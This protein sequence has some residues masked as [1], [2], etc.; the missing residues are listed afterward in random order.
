MKIALLAFL[1]AL[2]ASATD[3]YIGIDSGKDSRPQWKL[4]LDAFRAKDAASRDDAELAGKLANVVRSDLM[5]SRYFEIVEDRPPV[6]ASEDDARRHWKT[7]GA[8]YLL[9]AE[10]SRSGASAQ[11]KVVVTDL[12]AGAELLS[13]HYRREAGGWRAL[14]HRVCDDVVR[15]L[16]G[17]EGIAST[18]IAF[19]GDR[20]GDKEIFVMDYDGENARQLTRNRSINLFPRWRPDGKALAFTSYKDGN[21]DLFLYDLERGKITPL[22]DRQGLNLPGGFSR[23][24]KRL[25]ATVSR[26]SNP[27]IFL[28]DVETRKAES[29]TSHRGVDSSPTFSPDG[30]QVAF[31]S[32]RA[33]NPQI[34][35]LEIATG[36]TQRLTHL[37]WCDS[38]SWSPTGEWIAFSGR[39]HR[40]DP[41]DIFLV[42]NT[43]TRT[44]QLTHGEGSN[45]SPSWSPDGRFLV[46]TS[47]REGR[48]R[49]FR[50]DADG[51]APHALGDIPG[52]AFAPDWGD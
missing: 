16:T 33:G 7:R 31:I 52:N 35:T 8:V 20:T 18:K 6:D 3:V 13:R 51:S 28:I 49:V 30:L 32:D 2:P 38:P 15:Q 36:R 14:A 5:F 22:S 26:G 25:A 39:A 40:K 17:R 34:H 10:A 48:R 47:T 9:Q 29:I 37:N 41:I 44:L 45:E 43:G 27:N 42:D 19:T 46:F 11:V 23:D 4:G 24:G 1:L 21:P 12:E 50:M